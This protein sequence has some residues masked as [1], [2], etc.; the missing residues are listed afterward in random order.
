M[1]TVPPSDIREIV[2][3]NVLFETLTP[4]TAGTKRLV[5]AN[6]VGPDEPMAPSMSIFELET[7]FDLLPDQVSRLHC[8]QRREAI[9]RELLIEA[10]EMDLIALYLESSFC[11]P[12]IASGDR[13]FS[14]Y[15]WSGSVANSMT[16]M[17]GRA[18]V[19]S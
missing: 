16:M 19:H 17:G 13:G 7:L 15:G 11:I 14:I 5:E 18:A 2:R 4:L 6:F 3:V 9:E 12:D 1:A 10:D 8:L